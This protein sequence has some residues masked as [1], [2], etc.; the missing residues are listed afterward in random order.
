MQAAV[1]VDEIQIE[2]RATARIGAR[3]AVDGCVVEAP[4]QRDL[5]AFGVGDVDEHRERLGGKDLGQVGRGQD[6]WIG[7]GVLGHAEVRVGASDQ[8]RGVGHCGVRCVLG[9]GL[10]RV[11]AQRPAGAGT[12]EVG[13]HAA[14]ERHLDQ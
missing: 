6:P 9:A 3:R 4:G 10:K 1:E 14:V 2:A 11:G 13:D 7:R 12:H 8:P 5:L